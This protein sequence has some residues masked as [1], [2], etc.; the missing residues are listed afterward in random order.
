VAYTIN[1][2][3]GSAFELLVKNIIYPISE[4][5]HLYAKFVEKTSTLS[6]YRFTYLAYRQIR[7]YSLLGQ[8]Q[9]WSY[10]PSLQKYYLIINGSLPDQEQIHCLKSFTPEQANTEKN[11]LKHQLACLYKKTSLIYDNR[12]SDSTILFDDQQDPL[13]NFSEDDINILKNHLIKNDADTWQDLLE[14]LFDSEYWKSIAHDI[15]NPRDWENDV[16]SLHTPYKQTLKKI[17][18]EWSST[19]LTQTSFS[20]DTTV[21]LKKIIRDAGAQEHLLPKILERKLYFTDYSYSL[22]V[23]V[24]QDNLSRFIKKITGIFYSYSFNFLSLIILK[25]LSTRFGIFKS[26]IPLFDVDVPIR[27]L[28]KRWFVFED[29]SDCAQSCLYSEMQKKIKLQDKNNASK[30]DWKII[31]L[32]GLSVVIGLSIALSLFSQAFL[33]LFYVNQLSNQ[34]WKE[35]LDQWLDVKS[36]SDLCFYGIN[37]IKYPYF[38][39]TDIVFFMS[40]NS[41]LL[42]RALS[43]LEE[44][45]D[46]YLT[47]QSLMHH[48]IEFF[49]ARQLDCNTVIKDRPPESKMDSTAKKQSVQPVIHPGY[50]Q[51]G[52]SQPFVSH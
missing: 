49:A 14:D 25:K 13:K 42:K 22:P 19:A 33:I 11:L 12:D 7:A 45:F 29:I 15:V 41:K 16:D 40:I 2:N 20:F 18:K 9:G 46:S 24:Y 6:E 35:I 39:Y 3:N 10:N 32:G 38:F 50:K 43:C 27:K 4:D 48:K 17:I 23:E 21:K 31:I 5:S 44:L 34:T 37:L 30:V 1:Y 8:L 28:V 52:R 51:S 26:M 47:P 36:F